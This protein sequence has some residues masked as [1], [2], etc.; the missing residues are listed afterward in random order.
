MRKNTIAF[1]IAG[2]ALTLLALAGCSGGSGGTGGAY[3]G[4]SPSTGSGTSAST[5]AGD[6][7]KT[8]SSPLGD[9][10]VDGKGMTVYYYGKD[11]MGETSSACTG[12]CAGQ[13]PAVTATGTPTVTGITGTVATI[14]GANGTKQVTIDGLP[15]YT[16][17]GDSKAG[18]VNGQLI[19]KVWWAV[20]PDGSKITSAASG[21]SSSGY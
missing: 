8:A 12:A 7:L 13:W 11:T 4:S 1:T 9:I 19:G 6:T 3:G 2:V 18:D 5:S 10:V 14:S 15:I 16:Y 21:S 20:S 17:A